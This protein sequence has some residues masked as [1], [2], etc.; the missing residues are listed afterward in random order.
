MTGETQAPPASASEG[1][2]VSVGN[3]KQSFRRL[4]DAVAAI[5]GSLP[6]PVVIQIGHNHFAADSCQKEKFLEPELYL[7]LVT[8]SRLLILHG[9]AGSVIH[10]LA[11][12]KVPVVVPRQARYQEHVDDHQVEFCRALARQ[13]RIVLVEDTQGLADGCR[14]A[15][16]GQG[17]AEGTR[18]PSR[19]VALV[20]AD[21]AAAW[22][23]GTTG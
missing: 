11:S 3:A 13:G 9:G 4:L 18:A 21:L 5:A 12:G 16:E 2:F 22:K 17:I 19:L 6:Q 7:S 14:R 20:A 10:A 15:L 8:R 1:T 23:P